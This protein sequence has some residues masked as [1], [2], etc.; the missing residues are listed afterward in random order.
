MTPITRVSSRIVTLAASDIDTDRIIPARFLKTTSRTGLGALLFHDWPD[1][2]REEAR[3]AAILAAGANFGCGSSREH[4]VWA[5]LDFGFRVVVAPSFADIFRG[6]ALKNGLLPVAI[7]APLG[8]EATVDLEAQVL[9]SDGQRHTFTIEPFARRLLLAGK[10]ELG[11]LLSYLP[12]I[13]AH[14][15]P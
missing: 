8:P 3:G 15:R 7:D 11:Y 12:A 5:L 4:A 6:N 13:E 9:E 2:P 14:E 1:F 10:D